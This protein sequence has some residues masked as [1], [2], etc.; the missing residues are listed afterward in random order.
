MDK[1]RYIR[2]MFDSIVPTYDF[3]NRVLSCGIDT[4]W[5]K[6]LVKSISK[7]PS[8]KILDVC[9]G[10]GD[11]SRYFIK[12]KA[13]L[14]SLDFSFN[15]LK[16][17]IS[18]GWL[19]GGNISGDAAKL[20][21]KDR[22]FDFLTIAFG[23]R[24]IPDVDSFLLESLRVLKPDGK[25]LILELT[26]P[27]NRFIGFLYRLY[28]TKII[29]FIGGIVSGKRAAYRYL[30]GSI[31]TFLDREKL[32]DRIKISGF[33]SVEYKIKTFGIATIYICSK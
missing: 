17:G 27:E 3:L 33:K 32:T 9:C 4:L 26:R 31:E 8:K 10:T 16:K 23:I 21:F 18:K 1:K 7:S 5:R 12:I 29:P 14:F 25:L 20:P 2:A 19:S 15:M 11:L 13:E 28:L 22:E 24:N 6:D 30:A